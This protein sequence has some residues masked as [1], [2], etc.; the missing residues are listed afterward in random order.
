MVEEVSREGGWPMIQWIIGQ[1]DSWP[2]SGRGE[3]GHSKQAGE[4][5]QLGKVMKARER[6][7]WLDRRAWGASES[8]ASWQVGSI[9]GA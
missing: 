1:V 5:F 3:A 2:G 7:A 6:L 4:S 9:V 8:G